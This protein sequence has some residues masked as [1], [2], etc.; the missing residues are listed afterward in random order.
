LHCDLIHL[1]RTD[2]VLSACPPAGLDGAVLSSSA[3]LLR[4]FGQ[5]GNDRLLVVN[6]G[7]DLHLNPAPE[8]L[9]APPLGHSWTT[10]LSTEAPQYGGSG[11]VEPD[12]EQSNWFIFGQ[13][14]VLLEPRPLDAPT[15]EKKENAFE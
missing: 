2:A 9:L 15:E 14:A 7:R 3:F 12:Q 4:Y 6:L 10:S 11:A 8:P 5:D 13:A 1:R